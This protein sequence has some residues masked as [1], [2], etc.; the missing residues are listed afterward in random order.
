[1]GRDFRKPVCVVA[2][3]GPGNGLAVGRRFLAAGYDVVLLAR[4]GSG[5]HAAIA[6]DPELAPLRVER[7]D[8]NDA[9]SVRKTFADIIVRH[10]A[11]DTLVYNAGNAVI[12]NVDVFDDELFESAWR[13]N[14]FGLMHCVRQVVGGMRERRKGNIVITGATASLRGSSNFLS[15]AA[16]KAGQ[17]SLAQSLAKHLMPYG[18]HVAYLVIDGVVDMPRTRQFFSAHPDDFFTQ[19]D[20]VADAVFGLMSQRRSGWTFELDLRPF[21]EKW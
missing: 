18:I 6:A 3:A 1:M 11:V 20:D 5:L 10:G 12:D 13:T 7:C 15:F 17:R 16:A 14:Q 4:G 8:L 9:E 2:G 21:G 19:P